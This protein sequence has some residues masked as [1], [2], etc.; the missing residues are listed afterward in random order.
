MKMAKTLV[1]TL[2]LAAGCSG[3]CPEA[4]C[5]EAECDAVCNAVAEA[6]PESPDGPVLTL[7]SYESQLLQPLVD[8]IRQG[9][10]PFSD[11]AVG[12]CKGERAC[13]EFLGLDAGELPPGKYIVTAELRVPDVGDPGTWKINFDTNCETTTKSGGTSN[14]DHTR[15]YDVRYAGKERGYRLSPLRTVES[16]SRGGARKCTYKIIA[17]HPDGEKVYEGSWSTP[18]PAE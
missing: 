4:T 7:T 12:I 11:T 13:D 16:P 10:R 17:P 9:V 8:D 1:A 14:S 3:D 5:G 18:G 6:A 2:F 15:S